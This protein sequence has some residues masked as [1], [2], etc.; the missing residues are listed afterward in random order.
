MTVQDIIDEL[1]DHGFTDTSTTRKVAVIND[2]VWDINSRNPWPYLEA[3]IDLNFDGSSAVPSNFPADFRAALVVT[4]ADTGDKIEPMRMDQVYRVHGSEIST[5]DQPQVFYFVGKQMRFWPVP[6]AGTV[7]HMPYLRKQAALTSA[8][9]EADI[10]IP[11]EHHR[12]IV[13]GSLWK[14]NDMED[15]YDIGQRF[16][17]E[18]ESRIQTMVEELFVSQYDRPDRVF[19][20]DTDLLE[21]FL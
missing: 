17:A 11:K 16:Q 2:T 20:I 14:L 21:Y 7:L 12:A 6:P 1:N 4:R 8:S 15:D 10:L 5:V 18:Y 3:T 9:L 19:D 13:L